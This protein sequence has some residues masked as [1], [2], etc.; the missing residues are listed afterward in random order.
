MNRLTVQM[1]PKTV[2][3]GYYSLVPQVADVD[4]KVG[5]VYIL[6]LAFETGEYTLLSTFLTT[7]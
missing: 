4:L 5:V 3:S 2:L 1:V 6:L 7:C